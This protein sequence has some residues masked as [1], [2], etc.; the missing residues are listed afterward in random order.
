MDWTETL[1]L[2][3]EQLLPVVGVILAGVLSALG[4]LLVFYLQK[5]AGVKITQAQVDMLD[6]IIVDGIEYAEEQ[7]RKA[8]KAKDPSPGSDSKL[9]TAI[10]FIVTEARRKGLPEM[11]RD[12]LVKVIESRIEDVRP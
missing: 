8:L 10:A 11:A 9:E 2:L 12:T 1:R 3:A 6:D 7:A 4:G 5:W